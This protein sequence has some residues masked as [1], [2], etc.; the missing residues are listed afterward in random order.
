MRSRAAAWGGTQAEREKIAEEK[1]ENSLTHFGKVEVDNKV[2]S[3]LYQDT[4]DLIDKMRSEFEVLLKEQQANHDRVN[5]EN[6]DRHNRNIN[7]RIRIQEKTERDLNSKME[8]MR[9]EKDK[10]IA[11]LTKKM[12]EQRA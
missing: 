8:K 1:Y 10:I 9:Q 3:Q 12:D 2:L 4:R 11:D 6:E 7:E 5:R